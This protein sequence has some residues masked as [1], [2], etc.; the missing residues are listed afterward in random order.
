MKNPVHLGTR[1]RNVIQK[2]LLLIT[3]IGCLAAIS[4]S[5]LFSR[6]MGKYWQNYPLTPAIGIR[7]KKNM[8]SQE[9]NQENIIREAEICNNVSFERRNLSFLWQPVI[10]HHSYIYSAHIDSRDNRKMIKVF[11][12]VEEK[13]KENFNLYCH[14]WYRKTSYVAV[15]KAEAE[16]KVGSGSFK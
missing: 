8:N 14:I 11:T 1:Y 2:Y 16:P 12:I 7:D 5:Y 10:P 4:F 6:G 13:V 3:V 15:V 9:G